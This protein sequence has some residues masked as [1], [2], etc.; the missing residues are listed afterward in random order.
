MVCPGAPTCARTVSSNPG[1]SALG[2][3]LPGPFAQY[4][5]PLTH[6][7]LA[8]LDYVPADVT[9][10]GRLMFAWD[11]LAL[12]PSSS[13]RVRWMRANL[14]QDPSEPDSGRL[15]LPVGQVEGMRAVHS[16]GIG[17]AYVAW[18]IIAPAALGPG[19]QDVGQTWMTRLLPSALVGVEPPAPRRSP[20]ALSAPRPNP[21]HDAVALDLTLPD[22]SPARVELLDIAGRVVRAQTPQGAGPHSVTFDALASLAPGLYFA[23]VTSHEGARSVR[24]VLT[25]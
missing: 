15:I 20:L 8:L 3:P 17:G 19:L 9:P 1:T 24:V 7:L 5:P 21:S 22:D 23:R 25:R 10:D 14:T 16:D 4:Q 6:P 2:T 18:G 12:A 13:F 11:D